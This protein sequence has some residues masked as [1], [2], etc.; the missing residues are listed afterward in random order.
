MT[1]YSLHLRSVPRF[2]MSYSSTV[3]T[4][5]VLRDAA[6]AVTGCSITPFADGYDVAVDL[7]RQDHVQA[8]NDLTSTL[9]LSRSS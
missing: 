6:P 2:P 9:R 1:R 5:E 3:L 4:E 7:E 8:L